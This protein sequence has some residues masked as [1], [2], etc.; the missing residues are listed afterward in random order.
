MAK[1]NKGLIPE[2]CKEGGYGVDIAIYF[3][4]AFPRDEN[5]AFTLISAKHFAL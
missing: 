1:N 3:H 4:N 5:G 2:L